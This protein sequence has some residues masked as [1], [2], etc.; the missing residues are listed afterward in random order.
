MDQIFLEVPI[1]NA[2]LIFLF[3]TKGSSRAIL[4]AYPDLISPYGV[5]EY[6]IV[7]L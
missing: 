7:E 1:S 2:I 5:H 4:P 3:L 6:W